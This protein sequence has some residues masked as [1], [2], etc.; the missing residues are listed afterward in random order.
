LVPHRRGL[1]AAVVAAALAI[2]AAC[3]A[4]ARPAALPPPA[5]PQA[6][7]LHLAPLELPADAPTIDAHTSDISAYLAFYKARAAELA[8]MHAIV[9]TANEAAYDV[10]YYDLDLHPLTNGFLYGTV[11]VLASVVSGPLTTMD[12]DFDSSVMHVDN[13]TSAGGAATFTHAASVLT[14]QLDRAYAPDEIMDVTVTYH[15]SPAATGFGSYGVNLYNGLP[16]IW[17]LSE[18]YGA[19]SWWPCKDQPSDKADS[20]DVRVTVPTGMITAS[21]GVRVEYTDNGTNA[22]SHWREHYPI[23]SYLVSMTSYAYAPFSD[24]YHYSPTDSMEIQFYYYP[25]QVVPNTF[26]SLEVKGMISAFAARFGPYPFLAEKY[27]H[28]EFPW[29]GG[30][31][32]QT[33]TSLG[34]F[35]EYVVAH[36]LGHQWWGDLVT[37]RDFQH[38]WLNEGFATYCEALWVEAK[39]GLAAYHAKLML[40]AGYGPGTVFRSDT[41]TVGSIFNASLAYAKGSWVLHMLRHVMGDTLFFIA[42]RNYRAQYAYSTATT[43]DFRHVCEA[44]CGYDLTRFFQE[45]VY[46]EYYPTYL[47]SWSA[48][49]SLGGSD[50]TVWVRQTQTWQKF[51][52]PVDV[53]LRS[54][55]GDLTFVARD[56]LDWQSFTFHAPT[57]PSQ[58]LLDKDQWILQQTTTAVAVEGAPP[59]RSLALTS[60]APNPSRSVTQVEFALPR[61]G[62]ARLGVYDLAGRRVAKL[63]EGPLAAGPQ[64]LAWNG[65][66]DSG[67]PVAAGI[68]WVR[69]EEGGE[70]AMRKLAVMR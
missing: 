24:W 70:R 39:S 48:R 30:M 45:W 12:L 28:A 6:A 27:G 25:D 5:P 36:E 41:S 10:H 53:T 54:D 13:V 23:A 50:V 11:R 20:V 4:L 68:Y 60:L 44:T 59:P 21:N 46:G 47:L 31:E 1:T 33:C 32:H 69:V 61:A 67:R 63:F 52:M 65:A 56:S 57:A 2:P 35:N 15:G 9:M 49:P 29:G 66:D 42:L 14:I 17:T 62:V 55:A 38:V 16:I 64:R 34:S 26:V 7:A 40:N 18:P 43:E 58:V 51:W 8:N 37:C 19:H 3:V 22:Y